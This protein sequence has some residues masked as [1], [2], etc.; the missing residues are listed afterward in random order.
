MISYHSTSMQRL[1]YGLPFPLKSLLATIY[2]FRQRHLRYGKEF[3]M[4]LLFLD[5][6]QF[7]TTDQFMEYQRVKRDSYLEEVIPATK[8][9]AS[10]PVY[11]NVLHGGVFTDLPILTKTTVRAHRQDFIST[12]LSQTPHQWAKTSGTTGTSLRF[13]VSRDAF[14]REYAF[15]ALH[16][17]WGGVTMQG[18]ER[19]SFCA[20]HPVAF[21]D[22]DKPPFWVFDYANNVQFLSSYHLTA[23]NLGAYMHALEAFA[24]VMLSGYPSSLY[25][26]A[27]GY[28]KHGTGKLRLRSIFS[29]SETLFD[30]QR[31]TIEE[32]F[33]APVFNYYGNTEMAAN[34]ME[35]ERREI[36][37]NLHYGFEEVL[38]ANDQPC[39]PGETGRLICTGFGNTLFPLLRYQIGDV[40][41]IAANQKS[42]CGRGGLLLERIEGRVEEYIVTPD[43]RLAGRMDHIFKDASHV[44]EAQIQQDDIQ[45][46][47]IRIVRDDAYVKHDE[48]KILREAHLRLGT[49]I[50]IRFEY[51]D[52]I[53]RTKTGKFPFIKTSL[54]YST[55][56]RNFLG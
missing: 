47:V 32:A 19:V 55:I 23:R 35:C 40:V 27:L 25:L 33:G 22:R 12:F 56:L 45:E 51:V 6:S 30:F 20:G 41:T 10:H 7:W 3:L 4:Y 39:G 46:I 21:Y 34:A 37:L 52:H 5:E 2:G 15:R 43:G 8:Y 18:H 38:G 26:L 1:Y 29:S 48:H 14:R 44:L 16:N 54:D 31:K 17:S 42:L 36:H 24:P 49:T 28:R 13:P 9:Y 11:Q 50:R 53:E